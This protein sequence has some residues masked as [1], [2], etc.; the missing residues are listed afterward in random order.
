MAADR[1]RR[2]L[3]ASAPAP[4]RPKKEVKPKV[5]KKPAEKNVEK[6]VENLADPDTEANQKDESPTKKPRGRTRKAQQAVKQAVEPEAKKE[7]ERKIEKDVDE[8]EDT[9]AE[10]PAAAAAKRQPRRGKTQPQGL[11][12]GKVEL[13][14][15]AKSG[16]AEE[17]PAKRPSRKTQAKPTLRPDAHLQPFEAVPESSTHVPESAAVPERKGGIIKTDLRCP[18]VVPSD[19]CFDVK[20][21]GHQT[22]VNDIVGQECKT[23]QCSHSDALKQYQK[24]ADFSGAKAAFI[25]T[26]VFAHLQKIVE[27]ENKKHKGL[28][29]SLPQLAD[30]LVTYLREEKRYTE[31]GSESGTSREWLDCAEWVREAALVGLIHRE[32]DGCEC[33][34]IEILE[35]WVY[36]WLMM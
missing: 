10:T 2:A 9:D 6:P 17:A 14:A 22:V 34:K 16:N 8:E 33:F 4:D 19:P 21:F 3:P 18:F 29:R 1:P 12:I 31:W 30:E 26:H 7:P 23:V 36:P 13:A 25:R 35:R 27:A 11:D 32:D 20:S 15:G 28:Q 24:Q 5:G